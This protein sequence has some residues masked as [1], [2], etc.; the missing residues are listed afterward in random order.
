MDFAKILK[1]SFAITLRYRALW[2]FGFI[3]ALAGGGGGRGFSPGGSGN[4]SGGNGGGPVR[5]TP[6]HIPYLGGPQ[7]PEVGTILLIIVA[8][9]IFVALLAIVLMILRV[10]ARTALIGMVDEAEETEQTSVRSGFRILWSRRGLNLLLIE[11]LTAI[12][13]IIVAPAMVITALLPGL[14]I[15]THNIVLVITGALAAAGLLLIVIA[16]LSIMAIAFSMVMEIIRRECVLG[17]KGVL[18]SIRDGIVT[19]RSHLVD[20]GLLWLLMTGISIAWNILLIPVGIVCL[21][22]GLLI[23]GP[24]A[25]LAY[26]LS[27]SWIAAVAIGA[28]LF[29]IT[30]ILPLAFANGLYL[31]FQS[32]AWTLIYREFRAQEMAPVEDEVPTSSPAI[33]R[34][35]GDPPASLE[36]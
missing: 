21:I 3:L 19:V 25:L 14:L 28:P 26:A 8:L 20:V 34:P 33:P 7:R 22:L 1:R 5:P 17:E 10:L 24:P 35:N 12:A 15:F 16:I 18:E 23:G 36:P 2:L 27:R 13:W 9:V 4:Y 30:M 32:S 31:V 11:A 29:L 6:D